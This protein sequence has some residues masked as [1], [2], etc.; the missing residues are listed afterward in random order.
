MSWSAI[1]TTLL[2]VCIAKSLSQVWKHCLLK[3]KTSFF[4]FSSSLQITSF[5]TKKLAR[6]FLLC[7]DAN[8]WSSLW[9]FFLVRISYF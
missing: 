1:K 6:G 9:L 8:T 7:I 3:H 5:V 2:I 4:A